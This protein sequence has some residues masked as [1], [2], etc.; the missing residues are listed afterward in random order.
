MHRHRHRRRAPE[1]QPDLFL[2]SR[3]PS[4]EASPGWSSL[5]DATQQAV[6]ALMTRLLVTHAAGVAPEPEGDADER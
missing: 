3:S 6:T 4:A 1:R 5:P 2:P